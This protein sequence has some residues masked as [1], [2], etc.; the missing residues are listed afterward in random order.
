[1]CYAIAINK[2]KCNF[3]NVLVQEIL[4]NALL[5]DKGLNLSKNVAI[6]KKI[7]QHWV[8]VGQNNL[9]CTIFMT[10]KT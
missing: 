9:V 2:L 8:W 6:S 1:M 4:I 5:P 10:I 3:G 7:W